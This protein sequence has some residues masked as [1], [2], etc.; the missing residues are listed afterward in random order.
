MF[1]LYLS[2]CV[3]AFVASVTPGPTNLLAFSNG[4]RLGLR[5]TLPFIIGSAA[6]AAGILLLITTGLAEFLM[7]WIWLQ[8][9][10]AWAGTLW[11][12]WMAFGLY[13]TPVHVNED[14]AI[15]QTN[16]NIGQGIGLQFV[17]PKTWIMAITVSSV[18]TLHPDAPISVQQHFSLLALIFFTITCPCLSFW[19]ILGKAAK[20]NI[21]NP[22]QQQLIN[23]ALA[24]LLVLTI[25]W[26]QISSTLDLVS[27]TSA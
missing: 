14:R 18:F 11:L 5:A 21:S 19:A 6:S 17:N 10:L 9:L 25:W 8:Q 20:R 24:L 13:K 23:R 3:F 4:N 22:R 1:N 2:F 27:T 16:L 26:A 7:Q 15:S 12:S